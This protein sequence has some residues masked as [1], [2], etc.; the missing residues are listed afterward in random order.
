MAT[1]VL[2]TLLTYWAIIQR[3]DATVALPATA[4]A[5]GEA[6][7]GAKCTGGT[8]ENTSRV[9]DLVLAPSA[10]SQHSGFSQPAIDG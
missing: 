7:P 3:R 9:T 10:A 2:E 4:S 5:A 8:E 1:R 6:W